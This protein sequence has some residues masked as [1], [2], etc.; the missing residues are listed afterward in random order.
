MSEPTNVPTSVPPQLTHYAMHCRDIEATL[1][2]YRDVCGMT[3]GHDRDDNGLRV[4]WMMPTGGDAGI[5]FVFI[6][7]GDP[8]PQRDGD[9][10][11]MGFELPT[12]EDVDRIARIGAERDCIAW[13]PRQ[14]PPPVGYNCALRDPDGKYVEFSYHE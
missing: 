5:Y 10:G 13:P 7:D 3:L 8:A 1:A 6:S 11:H 12:R 14:D 2:F 4:A 9:I